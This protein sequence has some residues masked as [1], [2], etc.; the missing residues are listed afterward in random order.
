MSGADN[1]NSLTDQAQGQVGR[2]LT[3]D[4]IRVIRK[5]KLCSYSEFLRFSNLPMRHSK[6]ISIAICTPDDSEPVVIENDTT[7]FHI[8][9][10]KEEED[11]PLQVIC[12]ICQEKIE[13]D[14]WYKK[15]PKCDHCFHASCIDRWLLMRATCPVCREEVFIDDSLEE[16]TVLF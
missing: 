3:E 12:V 8:A 10:L 13:I 2:S 14:E 4:Q 5:S 1:V 6:Q 16:S 15:V 9:G 11:E 7:I